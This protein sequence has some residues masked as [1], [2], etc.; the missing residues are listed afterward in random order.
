MTIK[1]VSLKITAQLT[2]IDLFGCSAGVLYQFVPTTLLFQIK[3]R[4]DISF[5]GCVCECVCVCNNC[6]FGSD[7]PQPAI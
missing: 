3:F 5:N 7:L 2:K 6:C 1:P 4:T